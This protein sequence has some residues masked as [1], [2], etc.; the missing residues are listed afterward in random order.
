MTYSLAEGIL[1]AALVILSLLLSSVFIKLRRLE[2][3]RAEYFQ[4]FDAAAKALEDASRAMVGANLDAKE[5]LRDLVTKTEEA[6]RVIS[7]KLNPLISR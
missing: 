6:R 3:A 7:E 4:H 5:T 2:T 1:L